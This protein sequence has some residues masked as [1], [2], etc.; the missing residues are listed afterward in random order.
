[1]GWN[2]NIS[3]WNQ[4]SHKLMIRKRLHPQQLQYS[5]T[6]RSRGMFCRI[7]IRLDF[8][9]QQHLQSVD[10][11]E[12]PT[13]LWHI[14]NNFLKISFNPFTGF[15]LLLV[16]LKVKQ[17]NVGSHRTSSLGR[18]KCGAQQKWWGPESATWIY[19]YVLFFVFFVW[20]N[21]LFIVELACW[22]SAPGD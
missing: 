4:C 5:F 1:M 14:I 21:L 2:I 6:K 8:K 19:I 13:V 12:N 22:S 17:T 9:L 16:I 15:E 10:F 18:G 7:C 3:E 11:V 20:S